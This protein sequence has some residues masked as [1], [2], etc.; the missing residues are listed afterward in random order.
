MTSPFEIANYDCPMCGEM[1]EVL[2]DRTAG[3]RQ[4]LVEDCIVCCR[5]ST[6]TL[7]LDDEGGIALSVEPE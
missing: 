2:V 7:A 4:V 5:P 3:N 6:L 1:N